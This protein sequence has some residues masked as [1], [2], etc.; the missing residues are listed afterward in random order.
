MMKTSSNK[1]SSKKAQHGSAMAGYTRGESP[2]MSWLRRQTWEAGAPGLRYLRT[3][4]RL[5]LVDQ[6]YLQGTKSPRRLT[7]R[8][9]H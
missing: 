6:Q 8:K 3:M 9:P 5:I 2:D 4:G 1:L 7:K